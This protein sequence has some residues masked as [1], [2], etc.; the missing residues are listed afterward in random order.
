MIKQKR[1]Y[2]KLLHSSLEKFILKMIDWNVSIFQRQKNVV[3]TKYL[4]NLQKIEFSDRI[5]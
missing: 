2:E 1:K 4:L 5:A 3:K